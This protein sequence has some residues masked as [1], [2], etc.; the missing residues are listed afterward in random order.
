LPLVIESEAALSP[1][2]GR[3][4]VTGGKTTRR[5]GG[6]RAPSARVFPRLAVVLAAIALFVQL[7]APPYRHAEARPDLSSVAATL[8]AEFGDSA[9]LC[10]QADDD[11]FTSSP[12][13]RQGHCDVGCPLCQFAAQAVLFAPPAPS[14]PARA[15]VAEAPLRA[16]ADH[17]SEKP[18]PT[19]F[20]QPRAPPVEA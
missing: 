19:G 1:G 4:S 6:A 5:R 2:N 18:S 8:R 7:M 14:L 15:E 20:A 16:R 10:A 3:V 11:A 9:V 13:R 17:V 12:E